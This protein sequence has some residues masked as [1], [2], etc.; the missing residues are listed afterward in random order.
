MF[1]ETVRQVL[2]SRLV[3]ALTTP[4]GVDRYLEQLDPTWSVSE[5]RARVVAVRRE[6]HDAV[7]LVLRPNARWRGHQAGQHVTFTVEIAG[8]RHTRCFSLASSPRRS[9]GLI[10]ITIK[11]HAT[12]LVSRWAVA[13]ARGRRDRHAVAG[14][15]RRSCCRPRRRRGSCCSAAAAA[16]RRACRCCARC[17]P[18]RHAGRVTFLHYARHADEVIARAELA[19]LAAEHPALDVRIEHT[20]SATPSPLLD[21]ARLLELVPDVAACAAYVC[22]PPQLAT[23]AIAAW[24]ELGLR[25][26]MHPRALRPAGHRHP[27]RRR[28]R[29]GPVRAQRAHRRRRRPAAARAGRGR[30]AHPCLWLPHGHLRHL[31]LPQGRRHR[32][33]SPDRAAVRR[34]GRAD[35]SRVSPRRSATSPS[36]CEDPMTTTPHPRLTPTE[37]D[38]FGR[39]LDAIRTRVVADLGERDATYLK[40]VV[41]LQRRAASRR[42]RAAVRR[43]AAAGLAGRHHAAGPLQDPRQHG[44]RPQRDA[45][46]VRLHARPRVRRA[47][48]T[49]GTPRAR[50]TTGATRTTTC[51]TRSPTSSARTATS[52]TASCA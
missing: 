50:A 23:A 36:I 22:G 10:D 52:A 14:A 32:A 41:A 47:R 25:D 38:A 33:R 1:T 49:S 20:H 24:T 13:D 19:R 18:T 11:R 37:L 3:A 9:D 12:G 28:R 43:L 6:T 42:P 15:G 4:H 35:R 7:T 39:E 16:S 46:P 31:P 27:G 48:P 40:R 8:V 2:G 44:D 17:W 26:R 34:T 51:T 21:R 29:A 30:R 5:V 45:R